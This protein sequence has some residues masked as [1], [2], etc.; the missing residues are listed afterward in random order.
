[1]RLCGDTAHLKVLGSQRVVNQQALGG[2]IR[3]K[4][5]PTQVALHGGLYP[6][7]QD[8]D[9]CYLDKTEL[10]TRLDILTQETN[11]LRTLY[12]AV[13]DAVP[14]RSLLPTI[15]MVAKMFY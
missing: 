2:G 11:F 8:V 15:G 5:G 1:M 3:E 13:K 6:S 12:D 4:L 10:Q 14:N 9:S 7:L